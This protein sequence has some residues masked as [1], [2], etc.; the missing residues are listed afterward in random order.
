MM[1][2]AVKIVVSCSLVPLIVPK[3]ILNK[4]IILKNYLKNL[5][6]Q[7]QFI[8]GRDFFI[9]SHLNPHIF[10]SRY[11]LCAIQAFGIALSS[12]LSK[13]ACE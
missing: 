2:L 5:Q 13:L 7:F 3:R 8:R 9:W 4:F 1:P 6:E 11:P 10:Y 12:S